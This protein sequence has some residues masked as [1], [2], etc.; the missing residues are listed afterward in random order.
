[1]TIHFVYSTLPGL[2]PL[3]WLRGKASR[4]GLPLSYVG[5]RERVDTGSWPFRAPLSITHHLFQALKALGRV[6]LYDWRERTRIR[7]EPGD[8][9]IG[10]PYP[11]D[12]GR[13]WNRACLGPGFK[14]RFAI[15]PVHHGMPE[16]CLDLDRYLPRCDRLLG[17]TG[18]YWWDTWEQSALAHW[19]PK[20]TPVD[21]AIDVAHYPRVKRRFNP[22]G[23]RRFLYIGYGDPCKGAHLLSILFGLANA[24]CV[25]V[26]A[27]RDFP[28]LE[29]RPVMTLAG[30]AIERL[31]DECDVFI[32]MGVSDANPATI[33]EAMA[34]GFPVACTP[35]SGYHRIDEL[36]MLSTTDM[37]HNLTVLERLQHAPEAELVAVAD[38][39][40]ARVESRYGFGRF[41]DT[42][43]GEVRKHGGP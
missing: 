42:V 17:I 30:A 13:V 38:R 5:D 20:M 35:Q 19:K 3:A 2:S 15:T 10:H 36:A 14:A 23:K 34:W 7:P 16:I 24:S 29:R 26:G 9:L 41:C 31:A 1:M 4:L 33:L 28:N 12:P 32:T 8:I 40:R 18:P 22:P 39:A 25:W 37:R 21:M 6:K 11:G 27:D 43:L